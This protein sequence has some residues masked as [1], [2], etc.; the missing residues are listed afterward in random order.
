MSV[1]SRLT[2][3]KVTGKFEKDES[4]KAT[5][6]EGSEADELISLGRIK[7]SELFP[8][9][10]PTLTMLARNNNKSLFIRASLW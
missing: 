8:E 1:G 10:H 3:S 6:S 4:G 9:E 2:I 7:F 5:I